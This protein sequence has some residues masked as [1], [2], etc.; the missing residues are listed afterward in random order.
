[1]FTFFFNVV[2]R[3]PTIIYVAHIVFVLDGKDFHGVNGSDLQ[4]PVFTSCLLCI[5]MEGSS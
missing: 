1:M 3:Q 5:P 2:T 4:S